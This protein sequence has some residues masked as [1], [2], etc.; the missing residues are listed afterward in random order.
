MFINSESTDNN[1]NSHKPSFEKVYYCPYNYTLEG[2]KCI[3]REYAAINFEYYCLNGRLSGTSCITE[4]YFST[5][6]E[7]TC[8]VGYILHGYNQ[9]KKT[10]TT[11]DYSKCNSLNMTY[12]YLYNMCYAIINAT[13]K[14]TCYSGYYK[15]GNQCVLEWVTRANYNYTCP[16]G[17]KLKNDV[18]EKETIINAYVR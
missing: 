14:E 7:Y 15:R 2:T 3:K 8:P 5:H 6:T 18:C 16:Y 17:Y 12:S 4:S 11:I 9:C 10:A 13:A 1:Y